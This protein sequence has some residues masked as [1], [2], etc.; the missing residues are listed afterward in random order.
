MFPPDIAPCS[1]LWLHPEMLLLMSPS[2]PTS[3]ISTSNPEPT[4]SPP[5]LNLSL[6]EALL[7]LP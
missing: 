5:E 3:S 6:L 1:V 2:K 4:Q 7:T